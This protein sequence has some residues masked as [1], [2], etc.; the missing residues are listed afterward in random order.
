MAQHRD[1]TGIVNQLRRRQRSTPG[2][3][4]A[5]YT[6]PVSP[7]TGAVSILKTCDAIPVRVPPQKSSP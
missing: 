4:V 5:W 3:Q 1:S 7:A 6:K 2:T